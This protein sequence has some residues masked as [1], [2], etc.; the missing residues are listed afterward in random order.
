MQEEVK[1]GQS[2]LTNCDHWRTYLIGRL[3][4]RQQSVVATTLPYVNEYV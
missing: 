2:L 3:H 4:F 1:G